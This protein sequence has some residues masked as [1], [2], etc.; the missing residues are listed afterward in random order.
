[1]PKLHKH[2][3]N[4]NDHHKYD[5]GYIQVNYLTI[6]FFLWQILII[7]ASLYSFTLVCLRPGQ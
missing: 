6:I 4:N 1:M 5:D 2:A 3:D 7:V